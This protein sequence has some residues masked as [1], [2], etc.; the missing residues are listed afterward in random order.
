MVVLS[1]AD[2]KAMVD[3]LDGKRK[4]RLKR[5][6]DRAWEAEGKKRAK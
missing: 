3:K 5:A 4:P 6:A 2:L 1:D